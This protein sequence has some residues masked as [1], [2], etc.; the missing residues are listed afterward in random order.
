M[1]QRESTMG[2]RLRA[3]V[4]VKK[5]LTVK[6][7]ALKSTLLIFEEELTR[8]NTLQSLYLSDLTCLRTCGSLSQERIQTEVMESMCLIILMRL[9]HLLKLT[10][11]SIHAL[12]RNI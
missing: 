7:L 3:K 9:I 2:Q 1:T 10:V 12:Y 5:I 6:E 8:R 4:R 11:I